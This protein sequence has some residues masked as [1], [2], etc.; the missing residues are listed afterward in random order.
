MSELLEVSRIAGV[1]VTC[2]NPK[3]RK[4][5]KPFPFPLNRASEEIRV[6]RCDCSPLAKDA[7]WMAMAATIAE[8]IEDLKAADEVGAQLPKFKLSFLLSDKT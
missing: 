6:Y 2:T 7:G 5:P 4:P 8:R 3:C 1:Q